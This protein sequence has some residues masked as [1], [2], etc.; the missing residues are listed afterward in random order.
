MD[1]GVAYFPTDESIEPAA[2]K[3]GVEVEV[4]STL[5]EPLD[6]GGVG[7]H[8]DIDLDEFAKLS[9]GHGGVLN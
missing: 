5:V 4:R 3:K 6:D 8:L 9:C 1:F 2:E 7:K